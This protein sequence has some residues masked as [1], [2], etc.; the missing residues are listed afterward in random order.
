MWSPCIWGPPRNHSVYVHV[1][2]QADICVWE[3]CSA[4]YSGGFG[5]IDNAIINTATGV[6]AIATNSSGV[7]VRNSSFI[8]SASTVP[9]ISVNYIASDVVVDGCIFSGFN[10]TG[11]SGVS[12][13]AGGTC[14]VS[15]GTVA[16]CSFY[17]CSS[18]A[19]GLTIKSS[20]HHR[21]RDAEWKS[22]CR[23]RPS[24]DPTNALNLPRRRTWATC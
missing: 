23:I 14:T 9:A 16:N 13:D 21:Q 3:Q 11:G 8:G 6:S 15:A 4:I 20:R 12:V 18:N 10:G 2:G 24:T 19:C 5:T 1:F 22:V 7:S 17:N